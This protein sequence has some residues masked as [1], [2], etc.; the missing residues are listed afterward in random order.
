[1]T[2]RVEIFTDG[3]CKGNPGPGGWGA[4]MR[5]RGNERQLYG[6]EPETTNN[7]M[8]LMAVIRALEALRRPVK[9][10][11][12]TDSR[13]VQNGITEWIANWKRNGWRTAARKPVKNSDLWRQ[14][15]ALVQRHE[16][17]WSWVKGH[18]GHAGN[19]LADQ[20]AN[21][22]VEELNQ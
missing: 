19:E 7:R 20:L 10:R 1:M 8:E 21:R 3:A 13:Y 4:V 14:L 5:Y 11:V 6:G 15:D 16:V 2:E 12:T 9:A 22:G 17:E 18:S